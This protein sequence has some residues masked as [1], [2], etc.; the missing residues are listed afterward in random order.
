MRL[1][2]VAE[3]AGGTLINFGRTRRLGGA[4]LGAASVAQLTAELA[5]GDGGLAAARS[6]VLGASVIALLS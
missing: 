2:G 3:I 5:H 1:A 6:G 4:I